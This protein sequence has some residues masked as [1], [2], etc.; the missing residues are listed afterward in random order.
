MIQHG[1]QEQI[2]MRDSHYFQEFGLCVYTSLPNKSLP[3]EGNYEF[4]FG[5][6][7][8]IEKCDYIIRSG[9]HHK[10]TGKLRTFDLQTGVSL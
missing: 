4:P 8:P 7:S 1:D 9:P 6:I 2:F 5:M 10:T 3:T